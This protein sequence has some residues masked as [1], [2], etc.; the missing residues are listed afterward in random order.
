MRSIGAWTVHCMNARGSLDPYIDRVYE[1]LCDIAKRSENLVP[2]VVLDIEVEAA[3]FGGIPEIGHSGYVPRPGL[4]RLMLDPFNENLDNHMGEHL[5]RMIAHELHHALRW[6]TVGYGTTLL[7][8]LVSEGL[9]GRFTQELYQ[10]TP[11]IQEAAITK[12]EIQ[13]LA[14]D[15]LVEA[16]NK[17]YEH[18][19]W[20]FGSRDLPRFTGYTIGY[21]LV[22]LA[23]SRWGLAPSEMIDT[24]ADEFID[25]LSDISK[26]Q[27]RE[28]E[29]SC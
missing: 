26:G 8:A 13:K 11:E 20:F 1:A 17:N 12:T 28:L 15:A 3:K 22:G 29:R 7:G 6:E 4:M 9:C 25:F 14:G 10:N 21:E 19:R 23:M 27:F 2:D 5:E 24:P 16:S 18:D